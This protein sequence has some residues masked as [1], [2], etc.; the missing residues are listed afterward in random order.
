MKINTPQDLG[1]TIRKKRK[2]DGLTLQ[3]AAA[4]GE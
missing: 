4:D 3:E 1:L 2:E